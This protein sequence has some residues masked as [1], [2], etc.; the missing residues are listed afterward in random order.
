M[1][2]CLELAR[3]GAGYTA[4]NPMV[5]AVLVYEGRILGEGYHQLYG[6]AHAE[7]NCLAAVKEEDKRLIQLST[8][9]VSLEPCAH[10]GKTPPCADLI[11]KNKIPRVVV[12]CR[13]PFPEVDGKGIE[14]L[15]AAGV[16]VELGV[17]EKECITLNRRFF[18]YHTRHRP[19]IL[20][21]WAQSANL[22][23]AAGGS[24]A[25]TGAGSDKD[26]APGRSGPVDS[27]AATSQDRIG[28]PSR[29]FISNEYSNRLVH[30]WRSEEAAILVGTNTAL[31]D[32]P[33]L[34]VRLWEGP[35]PIRL[36]LDSN[37][38]LPTSLKVFDRQVRTIIFN[39]VKQEE[40]ENLTYYRLNKAENLVPQLL[41][42]LYESRILSVLVEGGAHLLQSFIDEGAWD[43]ARV[44]T[45][46]VLEIPDGLA[47]PVLKNAGTPSMETLLTDTIRTYG[48]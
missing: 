45:N 17:L 2:R 7:V 38:R 10:F 15:R 19:Y 23:I 8:L 6:Q 3:L 28:K 43:E 20:L 44:I 21:K 40:G 29:V 30:K 9:Y 13:D 25:G 35:Q 41:H 37:L 26:V 39:T 31:S 36:V 34:T 46:N 24:H 16:H 47:A 1:H 32:D 12:G 27:T 22:K 18:T 42:A 14:K 33:S 48:T 5:G 4:P 11:I